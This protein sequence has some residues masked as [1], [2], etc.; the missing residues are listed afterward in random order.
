MLL[1]DA[2]IEEA[3]GIGAGEGV[4]PGARRHGGGDGDDAVILL[5]PVRQPRLKTEV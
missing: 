2:D 3:V 1:G 5:R 4:E